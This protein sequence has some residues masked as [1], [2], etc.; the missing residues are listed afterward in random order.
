MVTPITSRLYV[1]VD[2]LDDLYQITQAAGW[3]RFILLG[4]SLGR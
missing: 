1:F 2:W 4:H 3:Q